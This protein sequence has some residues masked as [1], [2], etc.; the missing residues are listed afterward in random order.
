[1]QICE[2]LFLSLFQLLRVAVPCLVNTIVRAPQR[3]ESVLVPRAVR[4]LKMDERAKVKICHIRN[5]GT[6]GNHFRGRADAVNISGLLKSQEILKLECHK[7]L[8]VQTPISQKFRSP[9]LGVTS[10]FQ[11]LLLT[12]MSGLLNRAFLSQE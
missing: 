6:I 5:D 4:S 7:N 8:V 2:L 12:P 10:G 3:A 11:I 1:M 9:A